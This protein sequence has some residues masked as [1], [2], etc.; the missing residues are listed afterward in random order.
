MLGLGSEHLVMGVLYESMVW[1]RL[2]TARLIRHVLRWLV[3][4]LAVTLTLVYIS[5]ELMRVLMV[6]VFRLTVM[7][8]VDVVKLNVQQSR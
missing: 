6:R 5:A 8:I 3:R 1:E 4:L 7:Q 2:G